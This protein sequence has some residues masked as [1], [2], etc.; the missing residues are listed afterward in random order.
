M[1]IRSAEIHVNTFLKRVRNM[2]EKSLLVIAA[3]RNFLHIFFGRPKN[4]NGTDHNYE[5][6]D[7]RNGHCLFQYLY[8]VLEWLIVFYTTRSSIWQIGYT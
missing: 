1:A 2:Y 3:M 7:C 5:V 6:M 8:Y 4:T